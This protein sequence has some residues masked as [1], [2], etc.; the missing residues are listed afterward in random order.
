MGIK[1]LHYYNI[2][3]SCCFFRNFLLHP[4]QSLGIKPTEFT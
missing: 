4:Y 2:S 3:N 1:V